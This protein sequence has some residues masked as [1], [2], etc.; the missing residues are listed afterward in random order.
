MKYRE[1]RD[2][3]IV[4]AVRIP[5]DIYILAMQRVHEEDLDFS[6]FVRRALRKELISAGILP[7]EPRTP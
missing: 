3:G 2:Q 7:P 1:R 6:K 5:K 4:A